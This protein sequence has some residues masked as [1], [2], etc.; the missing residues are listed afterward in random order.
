M[1]RADTGDLFP[2]VLAVPEDQRLPRGREQV[3]NLSALARQALQI[4]ADRSGHVL[5]ELQK[6]T[7][8]RPLPCRGIYWS[9]THKPRYVAAVCAPFAVGIDIEQIKP[10]KPALFA[11]VASEAEWQ[12]MGRS[13]AAFFRAWTAKEAVVKAE[14]VGFAGF[15]RC[16]IVDLLSEDQMQLTFDQRRY[17]IHFSHRDGHLTAVT[18]RN[19]CCHWIYL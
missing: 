9:L 10:V 5:G 2:V 3:K 18:V 12:M 11:K 15:S 13:E 1:S 7:N 8:G 19:G 4:S 6:E 17:Y 14:G 16:R